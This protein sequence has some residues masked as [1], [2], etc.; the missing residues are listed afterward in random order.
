MYQKSAMLLA[1]F[2]C[3]KTKI[4]GY[5][6]RQTV[7]DFSRYARMLKNNTPAGHRCTAD[8]NCQS[9]FVLSELNL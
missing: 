5:I 9:L 6:S 7:A 4:W 2:N 8:S 3:Q 1:F